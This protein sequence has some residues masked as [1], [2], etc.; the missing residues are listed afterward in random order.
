MTGSLQS[1]AAGFHHS[2]VVAVVG[3]DDN[4]ADDGDSAHAALV[5]SVAAEAVVRR[6]E[7]ETAEGLHTKVFGPLRKKV[8]EA[9]SVTTL[10]KKRQELKTD[11]DYYSFKASVCLLLVVVVGWLL[12][13]MMSSSSL[14]PP[15]VGCGD[16]LAADVTPRL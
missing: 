12:L 11:F 7:G 1:L 15:F 5:F 2:A 13:L 16:S 4:K 10:L 14:S 9:P 3:G 8:E 6:A